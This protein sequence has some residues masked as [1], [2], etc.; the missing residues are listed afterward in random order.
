MIKQQ[1]YLNHKL[2]I[3]MQLMKNGSLKVYTTEQSDALTY[4]WE[5]SFNILV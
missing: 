2:N 4:G 3:E 5:S 1:E